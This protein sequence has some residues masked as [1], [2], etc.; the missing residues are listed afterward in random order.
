[1]RIIYFSFLAFF[2]LTMNVAEA[3]SPTL[4]E[5][6]QLN[7]TSESPGLANLHIELDPNVFLYAEKLSITANQ[8][9]VFERPPAMDYED[10]GEHYIIYPSDLDIPIHFK[11]PDEELTLSIHYQGCSVEGLCYPPMDVKETLHPDAPPAEPPFWTLIIGFLGAGLLLSFTPCVL[12]MIPLLASVLTQKQASRSKKRAFGLSFTYVLSMASTYALAGLMAA[13]L[14]YTLQSHLQK[15]WIMGTFSFLLILLAL[16]LL[17]VL[18]KL[19]SLPWIQSLGSLNQKIPGGSYVNAALMGVLAT[20]LASPCVSAPLIGALGIVAQKGHHLLGALALFA[21]GF[22][23]GL[24]LLVLGT[25]G[26]R[27]LP[28]KGAWMQRVNQ[29]FAILLIGLAIWLVS[30]FIYRTSENTAPSTVSEL[31]SALKHQRPVILEFHADWC[32]GCQKVKREVLSQLPANMG[33]QLIIADITELTP[34]MIKLSKEHKVMAP[35][36]L[37]FLDA[38]QKEITRLVGSDSITLEAV[39][40]QLGHCE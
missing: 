19:P 13:H 18:K 31:K 5:A 40:K 11:Q 37:I 6:F 4:E 35:P 15:P 23:L 20:L 24:P 3:S 22:G 34:D 1:M 12:P 25:L 21:L 36:V 28:K 2:Y 26:E 14:G 39:K 7:L 16:Y 30:P 8:P 9:I 38:Q 17:G 10:E 27:Y 32:V 29:F 33:C